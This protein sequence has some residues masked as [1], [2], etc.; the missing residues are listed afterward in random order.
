MFIHLALLP[1]ISQLCTQRKKENEPASLGSDPPR[2]QD[3][4]R[5]TDRLAKASIITFET[6]AQEKSGCLADAQKDDVR[7]KENTEQQ[8]ATK[9]AALQE[10]DRVRKE[11]AR[12]L[13]TDAEKNH[14]RE[15]N[16]KSKQNTRYESISCSFISPCYR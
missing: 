4:V 12:G 7:E 5:E 16:K 3:E 11:T 2:Q 1:I 9:K 14:D 8:E 10:R 6:P 15:K 13:Q